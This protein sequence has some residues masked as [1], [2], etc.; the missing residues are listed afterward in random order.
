AHD[1]IEASL[2]IEHL[3]HR[4]ASEG[5]LHNPVDVARQQT[6]TRGALAVYTNQEVGLPQLRNNTCVRNASDASDHLCNRCCSR[7][8]ILEFISEQ[9]DGVLSLDA[10]H[11]LFYVV[12]NGLGEVVVHA[13]NLMKFGFAFMYE[14]RLR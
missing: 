8:K 5:S 9:F 2:A 10:G 13:R 7:F 1:D 6:V 11:C 3:S 12:L 14:V 4:L